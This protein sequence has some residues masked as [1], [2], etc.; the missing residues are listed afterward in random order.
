M[1]EV[2]PEKIRVLIG[3][4]GKNIKAI[5]DETGSDVE[6]QDSG[7]VN[8]FA[9]DG[10]TL[11]KTIELI[12]SYVKDPEVGEVYD[13]VVKDI[14]E[15]GAFVEILP[16]VEGLCHISEL[17]YKRVMNVEEILK[18]GDTVKVKIIDNR[19]GKYS[20]SRKALLE[21][22]DDYVEEEGNNRRERKNRNNNHNNNRRR[23]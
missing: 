15:F 18:I 16:G 8:I 21:K 19:G 20:L 14:K 23:Y 5:I 4:G 17:A 12:N 10:P 1:M 2:N 9:P 13:G 6:I 11:E 7:I 22:P 3:P